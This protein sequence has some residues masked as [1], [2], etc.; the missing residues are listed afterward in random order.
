MRLQQEKTAAR[1]SLPLTMRDLQD[2]QLLT[3][4]PARRSALFALANVDL[5]GTQEVSEAQ[6]LHTIVEVG[7]RAV[8]ERV[9]EESYAADA[10]QRQAEDTGRRA[11]ARRRRPDW[12][13]ES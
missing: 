13:D 11:S 10:A 5:P 4:S 8:A 3:G 9:E 6:L 7:L 1:K 2:L 12:A